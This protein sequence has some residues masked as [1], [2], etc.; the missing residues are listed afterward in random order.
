MNFDNNRKVLNWISGI[1]VFLLDD[2][3]ESNF[4]DF[5]NN[6]SCLEHAKL[7]NI[8]SILVVLPV[9]LPMAVFIVD[10]YLNE[11][12]IF[13][14]SWIFWILIKYGQ[15]FILNACYLLFPFVRIDFFRFS[16]QQQFFRTRKVTQHFCDTFCVTYSFCQWRLSSYTLI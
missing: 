14:F 8:S 7:H 3:S 4:L 5:V 16:Q 12:V 9:G 6:N 13:L 11:I 2:L 1:L 10:P 15:T